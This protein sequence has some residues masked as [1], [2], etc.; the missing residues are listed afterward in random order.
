VRPQAENGRQDA[1]TDVQL[2]LMGFAVLNFFRQITPRL[3]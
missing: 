3:G 1:P 2:D